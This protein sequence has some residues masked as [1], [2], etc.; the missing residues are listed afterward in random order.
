MSDIYLIFIEV[1]LKVLNVGVNST[2][3]IS[4][5]GQ[6]RFLL[7]EVRFYRLD[8]ME[9]RIKNQMDVLSKKLEQ[10]ELNQFNI[11]NI[12]TFNSMARIALHD[13]LPTL[14]YQ[15][16]P[17]CLQSVNLNNCPVMI[18]VQDQIF[19]AN[20]SSLMDCDVFARMLQDTMDYTSEGYPKISI[21][22]DCRYFHYIVNYLDGILLMK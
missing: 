20:A 17:Y 22:R 6:L 1:C 11:R 7:K 13:V 2:I 8:E 12:Q 16:L 4:D 18:T 15:R 5:Y 14:F 21:N 19:C 9:I 10:D 3:D